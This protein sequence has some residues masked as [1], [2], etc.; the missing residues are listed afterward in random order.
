MFKENLFKIIILQENE[1]YIIK[2]TS[3]VKEFEAWL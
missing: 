1:N 3:K 2:K